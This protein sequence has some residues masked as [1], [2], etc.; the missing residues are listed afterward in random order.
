MLS[1]NFL[2]YFFQSIVRDDYLL[3]THHK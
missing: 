1:E 2:K 3:I